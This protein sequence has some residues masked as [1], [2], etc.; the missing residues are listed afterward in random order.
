MSDRFASV[1]I[2]PCR[3]RWLSGLASFDVGADALPM[4]DEAKRRSILKSSTPE[5]RDAIQAQFSLPEWSAST[6]A[7]VQLLSR[8]ASFLKG[9][10]QPRSAALLRALLGACVPTSPLVWRAS[11]SFIPGSALPCSTGV[12]EAP[13]A[14]VVEHHMVPMDALL[15]RFPALLRAVRRRP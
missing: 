7:L 11:S 10:S 14:V 6:F 5:D 4:G 3:D 9:A 1:W 2:S 8:W 15:A 13:L 12:D